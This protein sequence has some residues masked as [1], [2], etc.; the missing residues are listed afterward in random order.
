MPVASEPLLNVRREAFAVH[1]AAQ[2]NAAQAWLAAGGQ[3]KKTANRQGDKWAKKGDIQARVSW[4][5]A[6]AQRT[7]EGR[8]DEQNLSA[9]LTVA[10]KRAYLAR[11]L[12]T[13]LAEVD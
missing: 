6:E 3:N 2:Q 11:A 10:E 8:R 5:R 1:F 12:R 4:I 7:L 9:V 13:P